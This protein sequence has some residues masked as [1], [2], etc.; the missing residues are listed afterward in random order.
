MAGIVY[1]TK[2]CWCSTDKGDNV[3]CRCAI[4]Q[5][6]HLSPPP[7]GVDASLTPVLSAFSVS[8]SG[9]ILLSLEPGVAL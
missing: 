3:V 1:L 5:R 7:P 6:L 2:E 4:S 9:L 8:G